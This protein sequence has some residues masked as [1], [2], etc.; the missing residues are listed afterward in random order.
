MFVSEEAELDRYEAKPNYQT[1]AKLAPKRTGRTRLALFGA[2][3]A[4][5]VEVVPALPQAA[6][7][8]A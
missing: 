7:R 3:S 6:P 4:V 1:R 8:S 2:S 5:A